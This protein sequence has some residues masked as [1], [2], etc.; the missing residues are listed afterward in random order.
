MRDV[1]RIPLQKENSLII[2]SDNSGGIGMKPGD[3]VHVPYEQVAYYS[4]RV[5]VME[6]IAAGGVPVAV[7]LHNFCGNEPWKDML[8]GI[9]R[10]LQ[11]LHLQ[12]VSITGSTESNFPLS[13]SALGLLVLGQQPDIATEIPYR[14]PLRYAVIGSPLVGNEVIEKENQIAPLAVFQ[15]I[16]RLQHV[17]VWPVGS[18]GIQYELN[19][20]DPE[21]AFNKVTGDIDVVKSSGPATCFICAFPPD[22]EKTIKQLAAGYF[23]PLLI[24][25]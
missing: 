25:T 20:M 21:V 14:H 11:E 13:Q 6:C 18:K 3:L 12:E 16:C 22:L 24:E 1:I 4:F 19:Q 15:Q 10:G 23:H 2:A 8:R 17:L 9:N 5:A 7:V